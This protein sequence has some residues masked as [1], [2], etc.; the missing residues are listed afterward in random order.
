MNMMY[1]ADVCI[2]SFQMSY[3]E[4]SDKL[5]GPIALLKQSV[6]LSPTVLV[7]TIIMPSSYDIYSKLTSSSLY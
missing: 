5:A 2:V 7:C 3:V 6:Y 1:D 4:Q